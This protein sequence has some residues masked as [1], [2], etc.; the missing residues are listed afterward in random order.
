M[1]IES[2]YE[3]IF[4]TLKNGKKGRKI[5]GYELISEERYYSPEEIDEHGNVRPKTEKQRLAEND[6]FFMALTGMTTD[7]FAR[8]ILMEYN[9]QWGYKRSG[10]S[11]LP[12][13]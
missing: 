2:M 3:P 13:R 12:V 11:D 1:I 5:I 6:K 7:E 4:N 9:R 8:K 10:L